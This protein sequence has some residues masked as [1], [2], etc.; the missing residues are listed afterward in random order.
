[1]YVPSPSPDEERGAKHH[2]PECRGEG[3]DQG[4]TH[5]HTRCRQLAHCT[6]TVTAGDCHRLRLGPMANLHVGFRLDASGKPGADRLV[7]ES[8]DLTTHG[9]ILGMTG[10]GKPASGSC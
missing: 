6:V 5:D 2:D 4:R 10:S 1:M 9:A 7:V 8:G 3:K